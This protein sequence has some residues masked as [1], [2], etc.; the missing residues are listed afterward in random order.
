LQQLS[1]HQGTPHTFT[2]SIEDAKRRAY[3][4][5]FASRIF[6]I[7]P[8]IPNCDKYL[9]PLQKLLNLGVKAA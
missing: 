8:L 7:L 6:S 5:L 9:K 2:F 4:Q 1:A 3:N